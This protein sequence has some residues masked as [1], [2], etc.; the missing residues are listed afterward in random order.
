MGHRVLKAGERKR[1]IFCRAP[2]QRCNG[3]WLVTA[4]PCTTA[5]L[6]VLSDGKRAYSHSIITHC[7]GPMRNSTSTGALYLVPTWAS[8][9]L[10]STPRKAE[11]LAIVGAPDGFNFHPLGL[12]IWHGGQS[13]DRLF[14]VNWAESRNTVE[15]FDLD[16]KASAPAA[17]W[18]RSLETR[19][20]EGFMSPNSLVATEVSSLTWFV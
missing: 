13:G 14:A 3:K 16:S 4:K 2:L 18:V 1:L 15:V 11:R 17:R 10:T 9:P 7:Q 8:Q 12:S 6:L 19:L 20:G 5:L